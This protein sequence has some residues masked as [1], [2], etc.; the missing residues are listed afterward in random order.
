[1][2]DGTSEQKQ[3]LQQI[4]YDFVLEAETPIHHASETIGNESIIMRRK[5]RQQ[6]G[7]APVPIVTA[8]TMRHGMREAAAYALLDA[9]G[10]LE[11]PSLS[12]AALRLLFAGGAMGGKGDGGTVKLDEYREL[13]E[14]VPSMSLFGGCSSNRVI[15]GRLFVKDATLI[16]DETRAFVPQRVVDFATARYGELEGARS[17]VEEEQRVRMDPTLSPEKRK[18]LTDGDQVK[19]I[20]R[21][22][23]SEKASAESDG[24]AME[25]EKSSMMPRKFE[26][27]AQGSLFFW[28]VTANCY[29]ALEVDTFHVAVATFLANA[30]VGGKRGTGHGCL[31][32]LKG[33][34]CELARPRETITD[35]DPAA[36]APQMGKLHRAHVEA[37]RA[38]I[39]EFLSKVDA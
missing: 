8:D 34:H 6:G 18:L 11:A 26:R 19:A 23:A 32:A 31:R 20:G 33:F 15:P 2:A 27:L 7:W 36:L 12:E 1:M 21:I 30:R 17:H 25:K 38:R 10:M 5:I 24:V 16:C 13:C 37:R 28:R 39:I 35:A 9:I 22:Q 3:G 4:R 29:S 14:L